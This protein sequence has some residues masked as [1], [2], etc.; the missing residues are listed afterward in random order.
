MDSERQGSFRRFHSH[1]LL[2][3]LV[4]L[5]ALLVRV[6]GIGFPLYHWDERLSFTDVFFAIGNNLQMLT[7]EHGSLLTYILLMIW[8]PIVAVAQK[9]F[10]GNFEF[11]LTYYQNPLLLAVPGRL[12]SSFA[13]VATVVCVYYLGERLYHRTVGLIAAFLLALTFLDVAESHYM[14]TYALT[15][16]FSTLAVYFSIK[17]LDDQRLRNYFLAGLFIGLAAAAQYTVVFLVVPLITAHVIVTRRRW[18][19]NEWHC[20]FSKN[21]ISGLDSAG[22]AFFLVTPYA[23]IE[24]QSFAGYMKWF[25][26]NRAGTAWVSSEGQPVWLFYLKEHLAG[27][28]GMELEIVAILGLAFALFRHKAQDLV[29]LEFPIL[30]FV[31]LNGGPNFARY[32][33]P[34]LPFLTIAAANLLYQMSQWSLHWLPPR[35]SS[36][37]LVVVIV[38]LAIPSFLNIVRFDFMITQ[39]DTRLL[40]GQWIQ[41]NVPGGT[42]IASEGLDILGPYIPPD[43]RM[44]DAAMAKARTESERQEIW[45][46]EMTVAGRL[47]YQVIQLF[48]LDQDVRGGV[49]MGEVLSAQTYADSGINY[50]VTVNWMQRSAS[51]EYPEAFQQSLDT[52][53]HPVVQIRPTVLF[54]YDPYAWRTDYDA[55]ARI[56]VGEDQV[57]GP[58]LTIYRRVGTQ[59]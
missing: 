27:G 30:L 45:A 6:Y 40:A 18:G 52:F 57:G 33:V 26:L 22:L 29:L 47:G 43:R 48:R 13:S 24:F 7:Y 10:P 35:L 15:S 54:R 23:L 8:S 19:T 42:K 4:V 1:N 36:L 20:L 53:Y 28:M 51:D 59:P 21:L 38:G 56:Q 44:I 17:I 41:A 2:L 46:L 5:L 16:L 25:V 32:A 39:P 58:L 50:L 12:V 55:L 34:L 11:F 37:A 9:A 3:A 49:V 31:T 14:R